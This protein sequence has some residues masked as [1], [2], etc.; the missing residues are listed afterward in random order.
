MWHYYDGFLFFSNIYLIFYPLNFF[1]D[2]SQYKKKSDLLHIRLSFIVSLFLI[3]LTIIFFSSRSSIFVS[4]LNCFSWTIFSLNYNKNLM[5]CIFVN[6]FFF[7]ET[8]I[9]DCKFES[10]FDNRYLSLY[11]LFYAL[12]SLGHIII[13]Y[14]Y[15]IH[16]SKVTI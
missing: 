11:A 2:C 6:S 10:C 1:E 7:I 12:C 8:Y 4:S 14:V 5:H 16:Y 3:P 9:F 13:S 15:I